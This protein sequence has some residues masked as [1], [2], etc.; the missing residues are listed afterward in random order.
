MSCTTCRGAVH[1]P[2]TTEV[3]PLLNSVLVL[4]PRSQTV[5]CDARAP[6]AKARFGYIPRTGHRSG[7]F[8]VLALTASSSEGTVTQNSE[9]LA[10]QSGRSQRGTKDRHDVEM[11]W[12]A[13]IHKENDV[14]LLRQIVGS[15][16]LRVPK[17]V[18]RYSS[19]RGAAVLSG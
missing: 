17:G 11:M 18:L 13:M 2:L 9:N 16:Y 19:R 4:A 14:L 10:T 1:I 6:T 5:C 7:R 3:S 8:D 15:R 12:R